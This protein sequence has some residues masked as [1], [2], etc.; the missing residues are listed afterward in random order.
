MEDSLGAIAA[1]QC[2]SVL[3]GLPVV[4]DHRHLQVPGQTQLGLKHPLLHL[5][6]GKIV[7]VVQ[8]DLPNG[9]HLWFLRQPGQCLQVP[10]LELFCLMGVHPHG[11]EEKGILL[12]QLQAALAGGQV[13]GS[14]H[15]RHHPLLGQGGE[16]LIPVGVKPAVVI[17]GMGVEDI[18][19]HRVSSHGTEKE[20][21]ALP[22]S[23]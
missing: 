21:A 4:D 12:G 15:H 6:G 23:G 17:V 20:G 22:L 13:A 18:L 2:Q 9:H 10:G 16:E 8:A 5:P 7:V 19:I 14:I 3:M 1:Q 11:T